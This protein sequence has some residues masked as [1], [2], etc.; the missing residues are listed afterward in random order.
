MRPLGPCC[1]AMGVLV[2]LPASPWAARRASPE[3][4]TQGSLLVSREG[5]V[6]KVPLKHTD[7]SIQISG[8]LAEAT[9]T[10]TFENPYPD[11]I[12]AIYAFPLPTD[13][14]VWDFSL[15]NGDRTIR[16]RI[17]QRAR[18]KAIYRRAT[19]A[20]R[21][22]ALLTQERPNL[23][24][25]K[26]ANLEPGKGVKVTISYVSRLRYDAGAYELVFPMV[27]GPRFVPQKKDKGGGV[28]LLSPPVLPPDLRSAHDISLAV[29]LEA[30]VPIVGLRS[31]SHRIE[32]RTPSKSAA[33]VR[34]A[35]DD[36]IP[37]RDF[38]LR[39]RVA[40]ARPEAALLA[41]RASEGEPGALLLMVQPPDPK[42]SYPPV[43]REL[44]FVLDTSSSMTGAPLETAK[45][46]VRRFLAGLRPDDTF[47]IV[48]FSDGA[49]SLGPKMIATKPDNLRLARAWLGRVRAAGGTTMATGVSK[50]LALPHDP[51]RLRLVVFLTDGYIG[52]EDE[53]LGLVRRELGVSRIFAL[54][55]G[56]AVNRY[57]L[58][59]MALLGRGMV[60]VVRPDEPV[61]QTVRAFYDRLA[62]PLL[63]DLTVEFSGVKV[64]SLTP[65]RLPDLFAGEP[66]FLHGQYVGPGAG[67][68]VVR[69]NRQGRPV[70]L[71]L[72][73]RLP[74]KQTGHRAVALAWARARIAELERALLRRQDA[75]VVQR[76]LSLALQ[77]R[78]L[79]R[80]TAFVAVDEDSVTS[81]KQAVKV[82]VPVD[83]PQFLMKGRAAGVLGVM[84]A[85]GSGYG[86]GGVGYGTIG[87]GSI[88]VIGKGGGGGYG[89]GYGRG[90]AV[91]A[92]RAVAP[93]IVVGRAVVMGSL[94]KEI[95]RRIVRRHI[96]EVR[97]CYEKELGTHPKLAGRVALKFVIDENGQVA[98][99]EI[100]ST[101]LNNEGVESCL[102]A[103]AR[104]WDFP[105][106][107]GGGV[108]V[109]N[110]P[111]VFKPAEPEK[112]SVLHG[113]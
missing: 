93:R 95:L 71:E 29:E 78:I 74:H 45:K 63:T 58:E 8:F 33:R 27:V 96:N 56:S 76:I 43:P 26:V 12:E 104:R 92:H 7:V 77:H 91:H 82:Q 61:E 73:V 13:S 65:A 1:L 106:A 109:V 87:I 105:K 85:S 72:P 11:K 100:A 20:G 88:G 80:Y 89:A 9:V 37:N 30:G 108:V 3:L 51:A 39:Y 84:S 52:N 113:R 49:S 70:K 99:S 55:V 54:G 44:I 94:D 10:Q 57:L 24:T 112:P 17:L 79:T 18:A 66:L 28:K 35:A 60:R 67:T 48:R 4:V 6:V 68:V 36:R 25:Q 83:R 5:K 34:I 101:T 31:P 23:F 86:A 16:G 102:A 103:A 98:S 21:V 46:L 19:A 75:A 90:M 81:A 111:F 47:Q 64:A 41:H 69:G 50:A 32:T 14:A 42:G 107:S 97:Y 22:A 40:G 62:K 38:I 110:Y 2:C 53:V 59:E 15:R